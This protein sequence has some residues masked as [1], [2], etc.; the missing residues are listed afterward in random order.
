MYEICQVF[1]I[2]MFILGER[3][4]GDELTYNVSGIIEKYQPHHTHIIDVLVSH[5]LSS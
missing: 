5:L 1:N 3:T 4:P 2:M